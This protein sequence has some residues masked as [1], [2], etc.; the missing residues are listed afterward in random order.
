MK[1]INYLLLLVLFLMTFNLK[2]QP[3]L[4]ESK[5]AQIT[6]AYPYGTSDSNSIYNSYNFSLNL[7]KG[8]VNGINGCEIGIFNNVQVD[9]NGVQIAILRNR[10]AYRMK[11]IQ[12]AGLF[13][14]T[15]EWTIRF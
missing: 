15:S 14:S 1:K 10:V 2:A 13:N 11:G 12:I 8:R 4:K 9:M 6:I 5:F 3:E 7:W